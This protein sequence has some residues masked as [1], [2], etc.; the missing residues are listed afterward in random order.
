MICWLPLLALTFQS[1]TRSLGADPASV[2]I[3]DTGL[4]GLRFLLL[5]LTVTPLR[6]LTGWQDLNERFHLRRTFG[7]FAFLYSSLHLLSYLW[8]EQLFDWA[9][10]YDDLLTRPAMTIG[11]LSF[12]LMVPLALTS[13]ATMITRLGKR[14]WQRLH[15]LIYPI[16]IGGIIHHW[17]LAQAKVD[18]REPLIYAIIFVLLILLRYLP[19][20]TRN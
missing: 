6:L 1:A 4:W 15:Q 16:T 18:V 12:L 14:H 9:A 2:I 8:F 20:R 3:R 7:L 10:I 5:T 19:W 13:T 17:W 11:F